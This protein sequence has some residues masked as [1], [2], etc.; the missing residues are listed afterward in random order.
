MRF[1]PTW[2]YQAVTQGGNAMGLAG[3]LRSFSDRLAAVP[4]LPLSPDVALA[5]GKGTVTLYS[6]ESLDKVNEMKLDFEKW[7]PGV[8]LNICGPGMQ[9]VMSNV[10]AEL[11]AGGSNA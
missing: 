4:L 8:S 9:G 1:D 6:S 7:N 10:Q 11:R 5:E 3:G 2:L